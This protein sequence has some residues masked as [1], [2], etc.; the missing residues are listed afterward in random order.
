MQIASVVTSDVTLRSEIVGW[1]YEDSKLF[2]KRCHPS[3]DSARVF[4]GYTPEP[5][6]IPAYS[7]ILEMLA[8]GWELLGPPQ[9]NPGGPGETWGTW[10]LQRKSS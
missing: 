3:I 2:V 5:H 4:I 6:D 7:C 1:T 8:N 9:Q 10:W